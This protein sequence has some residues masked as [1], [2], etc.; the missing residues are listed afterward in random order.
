MGKL[1][2]HKIEIDA[3]GMA[4]G[5]LAT[6]IAGILM[7]KHKVTFEMHRDHGDKV[8]VLNADKAVFTGKKVDQKVYRRHSMYP[9]GL[10]E[11]PAKQVIKEDPRDVILHAVMKMLPKNKLRVERMKRIQFK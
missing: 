6:R 11:T 9:G 3:A 8:L 7:G 4:P 5:R 1:K 10:T 2:H